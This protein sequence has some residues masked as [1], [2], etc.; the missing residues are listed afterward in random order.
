MKIWLDA[1][2]ADA[3][4][5]YGQSGKSDCNDCTDCNDCGDTSGGSALLAPAGC[6]P[7]H[8]GSDSLQAQTLQQ[9]APLHIQAC[10]QNRW[11]V[12]SPTGTG[13]IAVLDTQAF[14]LLERF[15]TPVM[16]ADLLTEDHGIAASRVEQAVAVLSTLGLLHNP[17]RPVLSSEEHTSRILHA[18][19]HVTND[20][21]LRCSYC[22]IQKT[23]ERMTEE[24]SRRAVEAIFRS[25]VRQHFKGIKIKY[26][27]GEA[28]LYLP[29]VLAL[30]EYASQLASQQGRALSAYIISNGIV[31]SE[32]AIEQL[33]AQQIDLT[34][35]LDGVGEYHDRQRP[36]ARGPGSFQYVDRTITRV[37]ASGLIPHINITV[38][39]RN[40]AGLPALM[41]YILERNMPFTLS[42][43][44]ENAC[45]LHVRD[46]QFADTQMIAAMRAAF[47]VIEQSLPRY[48]LLDSL[49]DK[50]S[51]RTRHRY[52][53]PAGRNYLVIDQRG[54]IARC[55]TE[56]QKTIT[57]IDADDPLQAVQNDRHDFQ[58]LPV[59]QKEGCQTCEW[60]YWCTGGC[61]L[62]T[63]RTTGR[64]N[65]RSPNCSV[66][67]ALFPDALRLEA[68]RLL[69]YEPPI[70]L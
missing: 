7:V 37:L 6:M 29:R 16:L 70:V 63:Y 28:S 45:T 3:T 53:C 35:S 55:H 44:R 15:R 46:L 25:A 38:S 39:Q 60:R 36:F 49:I 64:N 10:R 13:N 50:A 4:G 61:P 5:R 8:S 1:R 14:L 56:I 11:L 58:N 17:A 34:I 51:L 27:G 59:E 41:S 32:R 65:I 42:Y 19:L 67:Q 22:Y 68:L 24:T 40:L 2:T 43:Y 31:L 57:S 62:V 18:W 66:Y 30:H 69:R 48:S 33:Q 9:A 20:C 26:A 54:G 23:P 52:T 47:S 12:C 21:N